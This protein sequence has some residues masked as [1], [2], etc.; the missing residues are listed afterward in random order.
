MSVG[1]NIKLL[2]PKLRN[3]YS[4]RNTKPKI[5]NTMVRQEEVGD[6]NTHEAEPITLQD[7]DE[8]L[9]KNAKNRKAT[10][11]DNVPSELLKYWGYS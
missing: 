2:V 5:Y 3:L 8:A 9:K 4:T 11:L 6:H 1:T 7:V 10:G